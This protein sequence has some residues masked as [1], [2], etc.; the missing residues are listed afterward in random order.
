MSQIKFVYKS[1]NVLETQPIE[2]SSKGITSGAVYEAIKNYQQDTLF[3]SGYLP[4]GISRV[5]PCHK[6]V[7]ENKLLT[8][9]SGSKVY[10]PNGIDEDGEFKFRE[11]IITSDVSKGTSFSTN[12]NAYVFYDAENG[13]LV[14]RTKYANT[15]NPVTG[16]KNDDTLQQVWAQKTAP[17]VAV[18]DVGLIWWDLTTNKIKVWTNNSL[19]EE[20]QYSI[21][22]CEVT[23]ASGK[24]TGIADDYLLA[25]VCGNI[26]WINPG[27][28]FIIPT[29]I[30][31]NTHTYTSQNIETTGVITKII[32]E[33]S[34]SF[35]D[36]A[37]YL[38]IN[39]EIEGP[40]EEYAFDNSKGLFVLGDNTYQSCRYA[41]ISA[42][43]IVTRTTA[44]ITATAFSQRP[45]MTLADNDDIES[46]IKLIGSSMGITIDDLQAEIDEAAADR[47]AI[48]NEIT[49]AIAEA[50][51][52]VEANMHHVMVHRQL[53]DGYTE[54]VLNPDIH[55]DETIYGT[56]TF[57]NPIVG[58][59]TGT[60]ANV[61][62][63][64]TN[65]EIIPS[66]LTSY[67][68]SG[69]NNLK[70]V[71]TDVR[72]GTDYV[73]ASKFDGTATYAK[74][75]DLAE[76]Y[77]TD[78]EYEV[79]TLLRWGGEKELTVAN[80]GVANAVVSETPAVLMNSRGKG[81]PIALVGRVK[82]RV[83]GPVKKHD[84]IVLNEMA[85]GVG[86]VQENASETIVARALEDNSLIGEKLV[87][88]VVKFSL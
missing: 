4:E 62:I 8:L 56:K 31:E 33:D 44:P 30:D 17:T 25:G 5:E 2:G 22:L 85:P 36:Y 58:S 11:I 35:E 76:I 52:E 79:G 28:S 14:A 70:S 55:L 88:C 80:F 73:S 86:K 77:E 6:L 39:G 48:R 74:W 82:V 65:N 60:A 38:N 24:I 42:G 15:I 37:L 75:A 20:V 40:T 71:N 54:S 34:E 87:L 72:I 51:A 12:M 27:V 67:S 83:L 41:F 66:G 7:Y 1:Q 13:D 32:L 19:W 64:Q 29:G 3:Q 57:V 63:S 9:K 53:P 23:C 45:V 81:Q 18:T 68:A 49:T 50:K 46:V 10:I 69:N 43:R 21:P 26:T 47:E 16:E 84:A 61:A 59:I 78:A